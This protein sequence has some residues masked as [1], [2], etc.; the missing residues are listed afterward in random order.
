MIGFSVLGIVSMF[1]VFL[2]IADNNKPRYFVRVSKTDFRD[3]VEVELCDRKRIYN[4]N[5][6]TVQ[7]E[8]VMKPDE[9]S[10]EEDIKA[11]KQEMQEIANRMNREEKELEEILRKTQ[12]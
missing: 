9:G 8:I 5:Y 1:I 4:N 10:W 2:L 6:K 3:S 7:Y 11:T 12:K